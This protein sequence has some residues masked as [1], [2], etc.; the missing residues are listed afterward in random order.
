MRK[1]GLDDLLHSQKIGGKRAATKGDQRRIDIRRRAED[2]PRDR[3]KAGALG[4]ELDEDR[5][6]AVGL[7]AG[8]REEAVRDLALDHDRPRLDARE[9][10]QAL[11]DER[12]RHVVRQ[13]GDKLAGL[14]SE[15][16][17][18]G[19]QRVAEDE[20]DV[21]PVAQPIGEVGLE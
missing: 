8:P 16:G 3:V 9:P 14:G 11:D 13:V 6:R 5:H 1:T 12:R 21:R 15:R 4:G 2:G 10:V 20:I 17:Q 19:A 18:V 7:R